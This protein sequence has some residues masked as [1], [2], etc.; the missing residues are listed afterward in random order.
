M[1]HQRLVMEGSARA[2]VNSALRVGRVLRRRDLTKLP[3]RI[4]AKSGL[5]YWCLFYLSWLQTCI[6]AS[7]LAVGCGGEEHQDTGMS[8]TG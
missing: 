4:F 6:T 8:A 1:G 3:G 5:G 2:K 7:L